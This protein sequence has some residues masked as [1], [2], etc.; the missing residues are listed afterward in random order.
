MRERLFPRWGAALFALLPLSE[1]LYTPAN[2]QTVYAAALASLICALLCAGGA[3]L[4][5]ICQQSPV[6]Q[7][8]LALFAL[9]PIAS[10]LAR[11]GVF[12]RSTVFS[13]R[14]LWS[15]IL[16]LTVCTL[17]AATSGLNRCAMW[18]LPV[19][20]LAG[21]IIILSGILTV[22]QLQPI[23]WSIPNATLPR[24]T[25]RILLRLLP[26][27]L[28]LSLSLPERLSSAA[29]RGLSAGGALFALISLRTTLL[30]GVHTAALLPYPNFSAAGLAA[31]GDFARHGEVFFAVPLLLCELG[32]CAALACVLLLPFSHS[33]GVL[34]LS[35]RAKQ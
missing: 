22:S 7:W 34:R 21:V 11:M 25:G 31:I 23:Y 14:P 16:L 6:L 8:L 26:A 13:A 33:Y 35:R 10:S 17:L 3:R 20:W 27:S 29:A 18:A 1:I 32:R 12:L 5:P 19:A 9:C 30:L 28:V 24:E 15:L 4:A 2:G